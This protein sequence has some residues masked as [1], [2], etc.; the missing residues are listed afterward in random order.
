[1]LKSWAHWLPDGH[2]RKVRQAIGSGNS[3]SARAKIIATIHAPDSRDAMMALKC[4][5][6]FSEMVLLFGFAAP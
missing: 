3:A 2:G 1:M 5:S 6:G 4:M